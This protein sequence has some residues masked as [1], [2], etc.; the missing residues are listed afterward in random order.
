MPARSTRVNPT[1]TRSRDTSDRTTC[2]QPDRDEPRLRCGYP[3]PC[4]WH[5]IVLRQS[6]RTL[7]EIVATWLRQRYAHWPGEWADLTE[8]SKMKWRREAAELLTLLGE[9]PDQPR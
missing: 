4:P 2:A 6:A 5:T 7:R 8:K 3:L 9:D 1:F